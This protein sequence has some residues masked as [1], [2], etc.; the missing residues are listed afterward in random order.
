MHPIQ[1]T[2]LLANVCFW[3]DEIVSL[4]QGRGNINEKN[5]L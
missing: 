2:Q 1:T 5:R 4:Q 3:L